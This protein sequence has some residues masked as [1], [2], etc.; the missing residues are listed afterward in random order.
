MLAKDREKG[1]MSK[2]PVASG[3]AASRPEGPKEVDALVGGKI[4]GKDRSGRRSVRGS[5]QRRAKEFAGGEG[6]TRS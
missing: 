3:R 2:E 5:G 6:A 1:S 4:R